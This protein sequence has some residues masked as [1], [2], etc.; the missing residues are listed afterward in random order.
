MTACSAN[1]S[2]SRT[3]D[4]VAD[5][6]TFLVL[7][8]AWFGVRRFEEF[9]H[10]LGVPRGT[11]SARLT[12]LCSNDMLRRHRYQTNPSRSE[13]RLTAK[14]ADLYP[15]ML[16]LMR[17]GDRWHAN[18][19]GP[20]LLLRHNVCTQQCHADVVCSRC[21]EP[22]PI[23][24][25]SYRPGPG[26]GFESSPRLPRMRRSS[27]PEN[28]LRHRDCSV[29]RTMQIVGDRWT[30]LIMREAYFGEYRF[31][32]V[33]HN[34]DIST[35]TLSNRLHRLCNEGIFER[36]RYSPNPERFEYRF[37]EKG[38]ELYAVM[39]SLMRWG[40]RWLAGD[41]G[42]P[43]RLR[44]RECGHDF[45]AL[46]VCSEC[47][48]PIQIGEMSYKHRSGAQTHEDRSTALDGDNAER[49]AAGEA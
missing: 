13:Y 2:V 6:W 48:A 10:L 1:C 31:H 44:H 27:K 37:T 36:R 5:P 46:I 34:L 8:E 35:N 15:S 43:L 26:A 39:I 29:A 7:R 24:S 38:R 21:R 4:I 14:A 30:Y 25:V 22:A 3:L 49:H 45:Q 12:H 28:F 40:D 23:E 41:S 33:Q 47:R 42:A 19:P 18:S 32:R 20:P 11:L 17:W 9:R 16:V